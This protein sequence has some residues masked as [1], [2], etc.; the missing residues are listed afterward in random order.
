VT[1]DGYYKTT[2]KPGLT[3][4]LLVG[5]NNP[6]GQPEPF[7]IPE[8]PSEQVRD[9]DLNIVEADIVLSFPEGVQFSPGQLVISPRQ[10]GTRY[11]FYRVKMDQQT[12]HVVSMFAGEYQAT[13]MSTSGEWHGE[14]DWVTLAPGAT[15]T[16]VLDLKKTMRGVRVG[17]WAPGQVSMGSFTPLSFDVTPILESAGNIEIYV[18]YQTG[19]HAVETGAVSLLVNGAPA[20]TDDHKGWSG[21]DQWNNT[22][23]L[24]LGT[25]VPGAIYVLRVEL[26]CDGG[27]DS[28]GSIFMSLN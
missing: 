24:N 20:V 22:Y 7:T 12:R 5:L 2:V 21:A 11:G 19:R 17:G 15:N 3:Y 27:T 26:K 14:T 18:L 23:H 13:F 8:L 1:P 6:G 28:T 4:L 9:I 16:F 25:Y 10:R